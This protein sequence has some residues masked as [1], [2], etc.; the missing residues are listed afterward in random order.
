MEDRGITGP[1]GPI[2]IRIYRPAE[3]VLPAL[4]YF[5]GGWFAVGDLE[6]HDVA[7][8]VLANLAGCVIVAVD[9]RLAPE[10]PFPAGP[11]DCLAATEEWVAAQAAE[12]GIDATR[13][14]VAGDSARV[15]RWQP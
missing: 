14:A 13:L 4:V 2:P 9:Y 5:H 3:G 7:L 12:I 11:D 6:T 8:R 10:R 15:A 1:R